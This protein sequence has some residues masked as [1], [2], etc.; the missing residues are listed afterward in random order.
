MARATN[1][2]AATAPAVEAVAV[3]AMARAEMF[4]PSPSARAAA[5]AMGANIDSLVAQLRLSLVEIK[6]ALEAIIASTPAGDPG[7]RSLTSFMRRLCVFL[8]ATYVF[9]PSA[10]G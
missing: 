7:L 5:F 4:R 9:D 2:I 3:P 1:K 8:G 6:H 10:G